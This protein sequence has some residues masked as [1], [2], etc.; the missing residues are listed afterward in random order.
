VR[1]AARQVEQL[2]ER[3]WRVGV[4][5][6]QVALDLD[7]VGADH[8]DVAAV[9]ERLVDDLGE[10]EPRA[11]L[12]RPAFERGPLRHGAARLRTAP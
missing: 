3:L 6:E 12:G 10:G 1:T 2:D 7:A 4:A 8:R 9:I 11:D 5:V